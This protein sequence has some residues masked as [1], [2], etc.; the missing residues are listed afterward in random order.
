MDRVDTIKGFFDLWAIYDLV[1]DRDY[2][3]HRELY[4]AVARALAERFGNRPF[5]VLEL[6]CGSGRHLAPVLAGLDV[7]LYEG[8]DLSPVALAEARKNFAV[9]RC[10]TRL[11]EG[12]LQAALHGRE[13]ESF[14]L[15][16]SGFT[17][18]HLSADERAE[19]LRRARGRLNPGGLLL[20]LD[21]M[22]DETQSHAAWLAAYCGWIESEWRDIPP[23]GIAAILAHIG[24]A[25]QPGTLSEHEAAARI[26]G[27]SDARVL[28]RRGWHVLWQAE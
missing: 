8:H 11:F 16:F 23:E 21:S 7:K 20:V 9:L 27:F 18:H 22:R 17:L 14:D 2:M 3:A 26:A 4:A 5:S 15:I 1:L 13:T 12:D 19:V 28:A 6:G 24:E 25:D 10:P